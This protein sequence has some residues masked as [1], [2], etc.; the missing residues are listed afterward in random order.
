MAC[1]AIKIKQVL[2]S[3][4]VFGGWEQEEVYASFKKPRDYSDR[5]ETGDH[6]ELNQWPSLMLSTS[7]RLRTLTVQW[8]SISSIQH[9]KPHTSINLLFTESFT[10]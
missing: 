7:S 9:R 2:R 4:G 8:A 10:D 1:R 6:S 5:V 3:I